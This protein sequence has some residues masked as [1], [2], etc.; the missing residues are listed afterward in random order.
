MSFCSASN[1]YCFPGLSPSPEHRGL[2]AF[3]S[4][5]KASLVP[6]ELMSQHRGRAAASSRRDA[7]ALLLGVSTAMDYAN[8]PSQRSRCTKNVMV[9]VQAISEQKRFPR[10]QLPLDAGSCLCDRT[11]KSCKV[12]AQASSD[13]DA[14]AVLQKVGGKDVIKKSTNRKGR[15]GSPQNNCQS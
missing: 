13:A 5:L 1:K 6:K 14:A 15:Y 12:Q 7:D 10:D 4:E 11:F 9:S 2:S 3:D 8:K